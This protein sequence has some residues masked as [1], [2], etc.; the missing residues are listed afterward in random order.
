MT[1]VGMD[2]ASP[3]VGDSEMARRCR[4]YD[5]SATALGPAERW[6]SALRAAVR[7]ALECPFAMN[8]WCGD[9][10]LLIYNDACRPILGTKHPRALGQPGPV[11]WAEIWPE[12][13]PQF[14]AVRA[15][16]PS[17]HAEDARFMILRCDGPADEAWFT[18]SVSPIRDEAGSIIALLA[19]AAE[20]TERIRAQHDARGARAAAELAERQLR[21]VFT[22][23]PAF[24]AVL[25]GT[26]H[27]FE[28]ANDAY[29][30]LVG[31]RPLIGRRVRDA[32]PEVL[33][34]GFLELLDD[35]LETGVPFV[36]REVPVK[37]ART[38]GAELEELY[39]D[40]VYQPLADATGARIGVVAH[41][42][43]VTAAVRARQEI[44]RSEARYRFLAETIP[45]QVWTATPDGSVDY[46]SGRTAAYFGKSP[47]EVVGDQWVAVVH[48]EDVERT[49]ARWRRSLASGAPYEVEFRL[50]SAAHDDYC[51]HLG[52]AHPQ[53]DDEGRVIRWFGTNTEIED[54]K[55]AEVEL[56]R[57]TIEAMEANRAKSD[58]LAAMSHELRTPLNAIG[59]YAQL[60]EMGVRGPITEQQ[61]ID[62]I[63]I[64]RSKNHLDSL[65][66]G[67]LSFAK[68]GSGRIEFRM[69]P[70]EV[71]RTL[72]HVIEMVMPQL[73]QKD[74]QLLPFDVPDG[75]RV[76]AD[77]D[78]ARQILLNLFAN[79]LKF[80]PPGGSISL[81]VTASAT[82]ASIGVTDSGVGIPEDQQER[83]FEP[84]VQARRALNPGEHGVGLG[85]A[86][87]RQ[88]ARAMSGDLAVRSRVGQ[89]STFTLT[90]PRE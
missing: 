8:L 28:F 66:A 32:F 72:D 61:R 84:F 62:L 12:I 36:G 90:L 79:S 31:H 67:V 23:A 4:A 87:S 50:W 85:L 53:R 5:W 37:L 20:T 41:G 68:L 26:D 76:I 43:D 34:Q 47:D 83:I 49:V 45:V 17:V 70:M 18:Y 24:L 74:L 33:E 29:L 9:E 51:W 21:D 25:R 55:R 56:E 63:K 6:P 60:I 73:E 27:V 38:P 19:V 89:G 86:I 1:A 82:Q 71:R 16:G 22:Q 65:V 58:F 40:F 30:Q 54:W 7:S 80:T 11:V 77:E 78:K 57:L 42:A 75:L 48:P 3:F 15:G 69:A 10:L 14:E 46:V 88:L 64:Q 59:G 35:V 52:R 81:T 44:E 39:V 13:A 2:R